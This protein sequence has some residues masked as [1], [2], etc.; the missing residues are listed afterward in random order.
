M[1]TDRD[2]EQRIIEK[3]EGLWL[4]AV[5]TP[6]PI[7]YRDDAI[8]VVHEV[9]AKFIPEHVDGE[10]FTGKRELSV[11]NRIGN[12]SL[13]YTGEYRGV[14]DNEIASGSDSRDGRQVAY[15]QFG[16]N[17]VKHWILRAIP[18]KPKWTPSVGDI[19]VM[20]GRPC[21]VM[22]LKNDGAVVQFR[23]DWHKI[24]YQFKFLRPATPEEEAGFYTLEFDGKLFRLYH[25]E[26]GKIMVVC[27]DD[28][29]TWLFCDDNEN[30]YSL[31]ASAALAGLGLTRYSHLIKPWKEGCTFDLPKGD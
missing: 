25:D 28:S 14:K 23:G 24:W 16:N 20:D 9:F 27:S 2:I 18:V 5:E 15:I 22:S 21:V 6:R 31:I 1:L 3:L 30:G 10:L 26:N 17:S 13:V 29:I 19:V 4:P 12:S 7:V 8:G 11:K